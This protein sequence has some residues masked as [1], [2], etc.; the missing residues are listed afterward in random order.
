VPPDGATFDENSVPPLDKGGLQGGER[1]SR[2]Y[3]LSIWEPNP[4]ASRPREVFSRLH[5]RA[6][7][8]MEGFSGGVFNA[9]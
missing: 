7:S 4:T 1:N 3:W 5:L 6:T 8:P 2:R 9:A